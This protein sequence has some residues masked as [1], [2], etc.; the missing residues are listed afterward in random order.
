MVAQEEGRSNY[1]VDGREGELLD[2]AGHSVDLLVRRPLLGEE[3]E[4]LDHA[5]H[6]VALLVR[7]HPVLGNSTASSG[8]GI[9]S[10]AMV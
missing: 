9:E 6:S 4:L 1:S 8:S 3:G 5:R 7:R 10:E 2:H